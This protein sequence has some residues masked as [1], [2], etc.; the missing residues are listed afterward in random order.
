MSSLYYLGNLQVINNYKYIGRYTYSGVAT[1]RLGGAVHQGTQA[2]GA[3]RTLTINQA[4]VAIISPTY[5]II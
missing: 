3:H 4:E 5:K 1:K 2:Q